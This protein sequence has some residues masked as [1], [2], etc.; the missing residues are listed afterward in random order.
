MSLTS[1]LVQFLSSVTLLDVLL[2][3]VVLLTLQ[4]LLQRKQLG[5]LPPGPMGLPVIGYVPNPVGD[6]FPMWRLLHNMAKKYKSRIVSFRFLGMLT[7][8][9]D[10]YET[11]KEAFVKREDM[12]NRPDVNLNRVFDPSYEG[13]IFSNGSQWRHLRRFTL[14]ML[15]DFG[16]GRI[17]AEVKIQTEAEAIIDLITAHTEQCDLIDVITPAVANVICSI[18]FN[19]RFNYDDARY[20]AVLKSLNNLGGSLASPYTRLAVDRYLWWLA[21]IIFPA[22]HKSLKEDFHMARGF[23]KEIIEE[24]HENF[25][26]ETVNDLIDGYFMEQKKLLPGNSFTDAE[27]CN[28]SL[29]LFF[30]GSDTTTHTLRWALL[31]LIKY[32]AMEDRLHRELVDK[33]GHRTPKYSDKKR[34]PY[35]HAFLLESQRLNTLTQVGGP[36][37]NIRDVNFGGYDIPSNSV[38]VYNIGAFHHDPDLFPDPETFLPERFLD[39]SEE[40]VTGTDRL[41]Q[42][43]VGKRMCPGEGLARV[44][45]YIFFATLVLNFRFVVDDISKV[46]YEGQGVAIS[47]P[48]PFKVTAIPRH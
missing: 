39:V 28:L 31:Y 16:M 48:H 13:I 26:G 25:D 42:F 22:Q 6:N 14:S 8:C 1:Y 19:R 45:I 18:A 32:P 9:I 7:I 38:I 5:K 37:S 43:G 24:H 21:P 20:R 33:I 15:R 3:I 27:L 4:W 47:R 35:T 23:V 12:I 2:F 11:A 34:T 30:G 41:Y 40:N 29:D 17:G 44:E 46:S 10:D 36:H